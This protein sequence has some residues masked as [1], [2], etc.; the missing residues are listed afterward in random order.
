MPKVSTA[1]SFEVK[2]TGLGSVL[3]VSGCSVT[4]LFK[5]VSLVI[6]GLRS[7][8]GVTG[9]LVLSFWV[10]VSLVSTENSLLELRAIW[11][12]GVEVKNSMLFDVSFATRMTVPSDVWFVNWLSPSP[13]SAPDELINSSFDKDSFSFVLSFNFSVA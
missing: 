7:G 9:W 11:G 3:L 10:E 13:L 8:L 2:F 6:G 4:V 1:V 12:D 5:P